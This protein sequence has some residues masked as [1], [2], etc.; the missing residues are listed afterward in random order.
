M[1]LILLGV[2]FGRTSEENEDKPPLI[3]LLYLTSGFIASL[4]N[5]IFWISITRK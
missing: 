5:V 1:F 4:G 3:L 2:F